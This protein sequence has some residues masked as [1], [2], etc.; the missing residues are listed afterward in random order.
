MAE[1]VILRCAT[2]VAVASAAAPPPPI[3][4]AEVGRIEVVKDKEDDEDKYHAPYL[5][6]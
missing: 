5:A 6:Y 3:G 4:I 1:R 2:G